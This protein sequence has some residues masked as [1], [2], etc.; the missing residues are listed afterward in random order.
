[1]ANAGP[2]RR[3]DLYLRAEYPEIR[4]IIYRLTEN[5]F[6]IYSEDFPNEF[7]EFRKKFN[8]EIRL[9]SAVVELIN[10]RP[11]DYLEIIEPIADKDI[12]KDFEGIPMSK[13]SLFN[14]LHSK[15]PKINFHKLNDS[16]GVVNIHIADYSIKEG[17]TEKLIYIN[18]F[19]KER[20]EKFLKNLKT[21]IDFNIIVEKHEKKPDIERV[22][23]YNPV[24]FIY[25]SNLA[26]RKAS[27]FYRRDEALWYDKVDKIFEGNFKKKDL[28]FY[29]DN[30]YSCYV[31]Y[32]IFPNIDLRNHLFLY[33]VIYL[34]PPFE[35]NIAAWLKESKIERKEFL[36][37]V[38]RKRIMLVLTQPEFRY[39][40][41]FIRDVYAIDPNAVITRRA[42]ACMQQIDLVEKYNNYIFKDVADLKDV[43][44]FTT[45]IAEKLGKD[46]NTL[47]NTIVWPIK[48]LRNSFEALN[49]K[50][51]VSA[52]VYGV[53][54]I[55]EKGA[56]ATYGKDLEFEYT[57]NSPSIHL[58][59]SLNAT[60]FPFRGKDYSD[61]FY[62][63]T[64]GTMLNFYKNATPQ[65][66]KSFVENDKRAQTGVP[67]I[68]P[69]DLI[70][71]NDFISITE[72]ESHLSQDVVFPNSKALIESLAHLDEKERLKK[73]EF[74]NK[75]VAAKVNRK[76]KST[77]VIDLGTNLL[78]DAVGLFTGLPGLGTLFSVTK[79]GTKLINQ[80]ASV[81]NVTQK[82]ENIL[83]DS[84]DSKN[85][86]YLTKISAV[87]K[88]KKK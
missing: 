85:I 1:M 20:L 55:I 58:A 74:Y 73:I 66:L 78:L 38:E 27:E 11:N 56:S 77:G 71:V 87:A 9:I 33:E 83:D 10:N 60:Y 7:E 4:T 8:F 45:A 44:K 76:K 29:D 59:H 79:S 36:G 50:G 41:G 13:I 2:T 49:E 12:S 32:S 64:M 40:G 65:N 72:L 47:F 26:H 19:E 68:N 54:K 17:N 37:L 23:T 15:F 5:E 3:T 63:S 53:N 86:K 25:A 84:T 75:K 21:N 22:N 69:I 80:D 42:L 34:T 31:D 62:A 46:P 16:A 24:N 70:E 30:S 6:A 82:I 61:E 18:K 52:S 51:L 81:R 88:L 35:K 28:Y 43:R 67:I 14:L 48:A 57:V 39:D